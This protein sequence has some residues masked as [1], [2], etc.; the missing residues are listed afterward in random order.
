MPPSGQ[1]RLL[2]FAGGAFSAV[3][4][5]VRGP[6]LEITGGS[7]MI[8][9]AEE[10]VRTGS[11]ANPFN[12]LRTGPTAVVPPLYPAF[13]ALLMQIFG[14][15]ARIVIFMLGA[16]VLGLQAALLPALSR[17]FWGSPA[18]GVSAA[19]L[20]IVLPA[21]P[22]M[23]NWDA[24]YTA[25]GL[26]LF[27]LLARRGWQRWGDGWRS[28]C[29]TG[30]IAGIL[31]LLNPASIP[32]CLAFVSLGL[33]GC[34]RKRAT[35][36]AAVAVLALLVCLPWMLRN[37]IRVGALGLKTNFGM[38]L[39]ASNNACAEPSMYAMLSTGCYQANHPAGSLAE[40][41]RLRELGENQYDR[42]QLA[43]A[44]GWIRAHPGSFV[45]LAGRRISEFW[46]PSAHRPEFR[47]RCWSIWLIT[48]FSVGGL[49]AMVIRREK[50]LG[51]LV[52]VLAA[53]PLV[54]Y[55]VVADARYRYP[56]LWASLLT[57]GYVL[58]WV[59]TVLH[60]ALRGSRVSTL[61][62]KQSRDAE[63]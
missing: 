5:I 38:T 21:F 11:F 2:L 22:L 63:G 14:A 60:H 25:A 15:Y 33:P 34:V 46:F 47:Y 42:E 39:H 41:R 62:P 1:I 55:V 8:T 56:I 6:G 58:S 18:P 43:R 16:A 28:A 49:L 23:P 40:A 12:I 19:L 13:L 26:M 30:A 45:R 4:Y 20:L 17:Q 44:V 59:G 3:L 54:Y 35:R 32:V 50:A 51:F 31:A 57:A 7:E 61:A 9:L 29:M 27:C 53:Y 24:G 48:A 37:Y 52:G 10:L 36:A